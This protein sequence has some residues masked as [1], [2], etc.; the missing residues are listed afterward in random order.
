MRKSLAVLAALAFAACAK[1]E[2]YESA[3]TTDTTADTSYVVIPQIDAGM[4]TDSITIPVIETR[5]D[6]IIVGTKRVGIKRPT[7][8]VK[9]P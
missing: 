2:T 7:V 1:G 5:K 8:H 9:K 4:K 6:T 3:G